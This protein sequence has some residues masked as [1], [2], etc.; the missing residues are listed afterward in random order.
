MGILNIT[1]DSFCDG[2]K[3]LSHETAYKRALKMQAEGVDIIDIGGESTRPAAEEVSV[4][5]ELDRV[6]PVLRRFIKKAK[7][8]ISVDTKKPEVAQ[9]ALKYGASIIND[10][11]GL[12]GNKRMADVIASY[13][14]AVV[15]MHIKGTP[16]TMQNAPKYKNLL[17]EISATLKKGATI[18]IKAGI[19]KNSI[20]IDPGIGFGK[21]ISHNLKIINRLGKFKK[22]GF[23]VLVGISRKSFMGKIL[24]L[25]VAD[26]LTPTIACNTI[27]MQNGADII[28]VHDVAEAIKTRDIVYEIANS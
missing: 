19:G 6:I 2:G 22:L 17:K 24:N 11:T 14:A 20:I 4:K 21:T 27:A 15:I 16:R 5:E 8:P 13:D 26:R 18:A 9:Q 28:R 7:V 12:L 10:I 3:H 1:P 23:P 25:D